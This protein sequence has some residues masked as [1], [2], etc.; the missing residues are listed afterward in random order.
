RFTPK[1][2]EGAKSSKHFFETCYGWNL[3]QPADAV[4]QSVNGQLQPGWLIHAYNLF[5]GKDTFFLKNNYFNKL[6]G[7]DRLMQQIKDGTP[8]AEIRKSWEPALSAFKK[9]RRKYLFYEDFE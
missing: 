7:T 4:F 6:A 9:I 5:P 8:E 3:H 2:N 1:P